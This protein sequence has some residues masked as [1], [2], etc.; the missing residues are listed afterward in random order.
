MGMHHAQEILNF[1]VST[2][3]PYTLYLVREFT[4]QILPKLLPAPSPERELPVQHFAPPRLWYTSLTYDFLMIMSLTQGGHN[5]AQF[6]H[7]II[8]GLFFKTFVTFNWLSIMCL[9]RHLAPLVGFRKKW[10][11]S[12]FRWEIIFSKA[13]P[14]T[15]THT[16]THTYT[17][18]S[19][20]RYSSH[21]LTLTPLRWEVGSIP[22]PTSTL[23]LGQSLQLPQLIK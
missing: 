14:H 20:F 13:C 9:M 5:W 8:F 15:H 21:T 3:F 4:I 7:S 19:H 17:Y 10:L 18:T 16:H 22:P 23:N 2:L 1:S 11:T 6:M 12:N